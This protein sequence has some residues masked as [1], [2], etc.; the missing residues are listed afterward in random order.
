MKSP[1]ITLTIALF[2]QPFTG[3]AIQGEFSDNPVIEQIAQEYKKELD[4]E[5]AHPEIKNLV[6]EALDKCGITRPIIIMQHRKYTASF[7]HSKPTIDPQEFLAISVRQKTIQQIEGDIYHEIGHLHHGDVQITKKLAD[8]RFFFTAQ[9]ATIASIGLSFIKSPLK[10]NITS[11]IMACGIGLCAFMT[12]AFLN[13][14]KNSLIEARADEFAYSKLLEHGKLH[15]ALGIISDYLW[16]HEYGEKNIP[17][18]IS[19]YPT[20]LN[21]A[22]MGLQII[23]DNG[24]NIVELMQNLPEELDSGVKEHILNQI[25]KNL[26]EFLKN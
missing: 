24:Y 14:Y 26:P 13:Q 10:S 2:L 5:V 11:S 25:Q 12:G 1:L 23:K 21:R 22:R 4:A 20:R 7:A 8:R 16:Y 15:I 18:F 17:F 19:G 6:Q 3:Y 9:A